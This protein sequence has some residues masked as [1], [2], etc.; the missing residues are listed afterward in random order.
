MTTMAANPTTKKRVRKSKAA[1]A[2]APADAGPP[3][4]FVHDA[5]PAWG[6]AVV[7]EALDDRTRYAFEDGQSRTFLRAR[8]SLTEVDVPDDEGEPLARKLLGL[9]AKKATA[10]TKAKAKTKAAA[11][12]KTKAAK[13]E[14]E[15]EAEPE[16][17][18]D[19]EAS[20]E[21]EDADD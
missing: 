8:D 4:F 3:R 2:A 12:T 9:R 20:D 1:S 21:A 13:P 18:P 17:D 19:Q 5:R 14:P 10:E 15:A 16:A 6:R 7:E 11:K